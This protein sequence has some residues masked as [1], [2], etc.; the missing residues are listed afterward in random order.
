MKVLI[1][2]PN[3]AAGKSLLDFVR[4]KVEK[5]GDFSARL[6]EARVILKLSKS[7]IRENKICE[8]RGIISGNDLFVEKKAT[9]FKE[10]S[11]K[12]VDAMKRQITDLK[13]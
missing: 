12:A 2:T 3:V 9:T 7:D 10:A 4:E 1:Q 8:I 6:L 13:G 5:L 11:M